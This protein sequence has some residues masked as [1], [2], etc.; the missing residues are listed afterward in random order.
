VTADVLKTALR[1]VRT[2]RFG[3]TLASAGWAR[4]STTSGWFDEPV[5]SDDVEGLAAAFPNFRHAE[6]SI[7]PG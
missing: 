1:D 2:G 3:R 7:T 6:S 4:H 5:S